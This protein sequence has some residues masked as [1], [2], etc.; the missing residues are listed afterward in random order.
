VQCAVVRC[1]V[2]TIL[3]VNSRSL[4]S[5]LSALMSSL[6][7]QWNP[8]CCNMSQCVAVCCR[9]IC[10]SVCVAVCCNVST[11]LWVNSG[12]PLSSLNA[13]MSCLLLQYVAVCRSVL[14]CSVFQCSVLQCVA[15]WAQLC[16]STRGASWAHPVHS[17]A[18]CCCTVL[19]HCVAVRRSVLQCV[20]VCCVA[21]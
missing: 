3:R 9:L 5:S 8:V 7:L 11:I 20:D 18:V 6:L 16:K 13:F 21:V 12:S 17:W 2:S 4:L 10:Y 15:M 1:N 19:Q 14:Q